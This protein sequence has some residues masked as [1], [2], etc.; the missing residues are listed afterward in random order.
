MDH[1]FLILSWAEN[2]YT[3]LLYNQYSRAGTAIDIAVQHLKAVAIKYLKLIV[4]TVACYGLSLFNKIGILVLYFIIVYMVT[5]NCILLCLD[6]ILISTLYFKIYFLESCN[7]LKSIALRP[8]FIL[9]A[10][11]EI[12]FCFGKMLFSAWMDTLF[13]FWFWVLNIKYTTVVVILLFA[14]PCHHNQHHIVNHSTVWKELWMNTCNGKKQYV[15]RC[16]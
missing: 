8:Q 7:A 9:K 16:L 11:F 1:V 2:E 15:R 6:L 10:A 14:C 5:I 12:Y 3:I 4:C 13:S